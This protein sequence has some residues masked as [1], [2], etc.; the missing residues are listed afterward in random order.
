MENSKIALGLNFENPWIKS[1]NCKCHFE[2]K[3]L[4]N[5]H[6]PYD[7]QPKKYPSVYTFQYM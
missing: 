5:L 1:D 2:V 4:H 3:I 6:N 7:F